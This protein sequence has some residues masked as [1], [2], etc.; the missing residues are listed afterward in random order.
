MQTEKR[1]LRAGNKNKE[2]KGILENKMRNI[3]RFLCWLKAVNK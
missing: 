1:M 3:I 2:G